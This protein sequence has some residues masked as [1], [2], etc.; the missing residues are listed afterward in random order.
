MLDKGESEPDELGSPALEPKSI[1]KDENYSWRWAVWPALVAMEDEV[2]G[3]IGAATPAV[4]EPRLSF[5]SVGASSLPLG[6]RPWL[7]WNF[8]VASTVEPSHF[9]LGVPLNEPS[10]AR[11]C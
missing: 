4:C 9:P 6:F 7:A 5:C 3:G 11:A 8:L 10:L 2:I 1:C